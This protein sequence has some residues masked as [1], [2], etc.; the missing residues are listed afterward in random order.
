MNIL[1]V[2][3]VRA[4]A[5]ILMLGLAKN[6]RSKSSVLAYSNALP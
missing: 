4:A 6:S 5:G 1:S 2:S 3:P